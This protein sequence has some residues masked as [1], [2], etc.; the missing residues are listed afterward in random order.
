MLHKSLSIILLSCL[1]VISCSPVK[2]VGQGN[3]TIEGSELKGVN[4]KLASLENDTTPLRY[5]IY[6]QLV[7]DSD[8]MYGQGTC[9][10]IN[11]TYNLDDK[12]KKIRLQNLIMSWK[13]CNDNGIEKR[14]LELLKKANYYNI[15]NGKLLLYDEQKKLASFAR[16]R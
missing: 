3:T 7:E 4:W 8:K 9:N 13:A 16:D 2:K 10:T 11:G 5:N 12:Y 14:Y 15:E 1:L 6:F